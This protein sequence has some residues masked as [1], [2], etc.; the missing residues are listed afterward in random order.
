MAVLLS[1]Q[2]GAYLERDVLVGDVSHDGVYRG[3][4]RRL[5]GWGVPGP[6]SR[7]RLSFV[8]KTGPRP[9]AGCTLR[10]TIDAPQFQ[11]TADGMAVASSVIIEA[12]LP[13]VI[14]SEQLRGW[15]ANANLREYI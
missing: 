1:L 4:H 10:S 9:P 15:N 7:E 12:P 11:Q 6:S 14:C 13:A 5:A 2:A 3:G 8:R